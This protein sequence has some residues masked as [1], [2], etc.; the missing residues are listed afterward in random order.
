MPKFYQKEPV[1]KFIPL[2]GAGTVN[3]NFFVYE[4]GNDILIVDCGIG[5]PESEQLGIDVVVPDISYLRDK[6]RMIRGIVIT[7]GH[8]DHRGALPYVLQ[9]LGRPPIYATKL[10]RGLIQKHLQEFN[11]L[12]GTSLHLIDPESDGF[13]L[14][15]F[16]ITP[17]RVNH[18]IPDSLG[19][20]IKT[21]VGQIVHASDFKFDWTP[22][23]GRRFEVA[24]LAKLAEAGVYVLV[25]DCLGA[26]TPGYTQS[27][28]HIEEVF[29]R[30]IRKASGQVFVTT[31]SSNISRIQQAINA[32]TKLKRRVCF[33]GRSVEQNCQVAENLGYLKMPQPSLSL[34][35]AKRL[36]Q[37][38]ITYIIA[39]SYGQPDSALTR[40]AQKEHRSIR[41]EKGALVIFSA[42]P[43]PGVYDQVNQVID[44]LIGLGADVVYYETQESLHVSGHGS[45]GDLSLLI[46]LTQPEYFIPVG[47]SPHH[48]RAYSRLV[49]KMGYDSQKVLEL[50]NGQILKIGQEQISLGGQVKIEH[51]LVDGLSVGDVGRIVLQDRQVLSAEGIFVV[52]VKKGKRGEF[53]PSVNIVSRGFVYMAES[54]ELIDQAVALVRKE[55]EGQKISSWEKIKGRIENKLVHFLY[56]KTERRPMVL[57]VLVD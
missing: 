14:G 18:S 7:H 33:L 24:K 31:V 12:S 17:F 1:L 4:Y 3:L 48:M 47:G 36:P 28:R 40:L 49:E 10:V 6:R 2:G 57:P 53:R 15:V 39:G 37:N 34:D 54:E 56:R 55:I 51:V 38:S 8:E 25:S 26:T 41:M 50:E 30:E 13:E 46:A 16:K 22:V 9:D 19:F 52:I 35:Q 27:E 45:Q 32:S 43:I 44:K 29:E 20:S 23:D 5:F 21:P 42:D 11:L